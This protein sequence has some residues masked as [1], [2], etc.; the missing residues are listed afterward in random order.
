MYPVESKTGRTPTSNA[1]TLSCVEIHTK[2]VKEPTEFEQYM[3]N[4]NEQ[5]TIKR[6]PRQ[7][8][9]AEN[10][11][12]CKSENSQIDE[13]SE[14]QDADCEATVHTSHEKPVLKIPIT[15]RCLI[16]LFQSSNYD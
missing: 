6:Q 2:E 9:V 8:N 7:E 1:D 13:L 10:E 14:E 3:E 15:V 5:L 16:E 12:V 4:F 11:S